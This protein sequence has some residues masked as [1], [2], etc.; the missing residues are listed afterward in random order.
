MSRSILILA[1][2]CM[3]I[4]MNVPN[5]ASQDNPVVVMETSLGNITIELFQDKAPISVENFLAYV[6]NS[7]YNGTVFHRVIE[8][9]M[10]QGGGMTADLRPKTTRTAIKNEAGNG[11]SN[12]RGTLAMARTNVID[13]ATSQFFIN[14]V[15]NSRSLDHKGNDPQGYGYAVF[16]KVTDGMNIVDKIAAVQTRA[17]SGHND[18]PVVPV[19]INGVTAK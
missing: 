12:G 17:Q 11:L 13:S 5:T 16:G 4:T 2:V 15:N 18:V 6:N 9:F 14:T 19:V 10:I 1:M 3:A 7:Y 8:K